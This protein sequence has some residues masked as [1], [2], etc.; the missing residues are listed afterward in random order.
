MTSHD[1]ELLYSLEC[2]TSN[3]CQESMRNVVSESLGHLLTVDQ[4]SDAR[5]AV[6]TLISLV[7]M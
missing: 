3:G 2:S 6:F 7:P 4:A 1:V 5:K